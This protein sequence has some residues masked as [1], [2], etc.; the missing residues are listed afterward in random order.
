MVGG[1]LEVAGKYCMKGGIVPLPRNSFARIYT[2][3]MWEMFR[4]KIV[5]LSLRFVS[6]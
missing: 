3:K 4:W 2:G 6:S 5:R 1:L